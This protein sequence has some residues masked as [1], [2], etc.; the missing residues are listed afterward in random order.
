MTFT[1]PPIFSEMP[2]LLIF[3]Y[4][5]VQRL[6][7]GCS[8]K[9]AFIAA[10]ILLCRRAR[11]PGF[12]WFLPL[13][14]SLDVCFQTSQ[15]HEGEV[16]RCPSPHRRRLTETATDGLEFRSS[17]KRLEPFCL[18][19]F[20][21]LPPPRPF[22]SGNASPKDLP[23]SRP[24]LDRFRGPEPPLSLTMHNFRGNL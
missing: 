10:L 21:V 15:R 6:R 19:T 8:A 20:R 3:L 14:S 7:A 12:S 11:V 22:S 13:S 9:D 2:S 4:Y 23:R 5:N 24:K 18:S 17:L 16:L 1:Q